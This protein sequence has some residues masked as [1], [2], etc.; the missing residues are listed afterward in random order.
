MT[1]PKRTLFIDDGDIV[2]KRN[3][4]RITHAAEKYEGNP[5]VSADQ[6]WEGDDVSMAGTVR[7]DNGRFRMWY[8]NTA[9]QTNFNLYAESGDGINWAK[10][11]LGMYEDFS[12]STENNIYMSRVGIR[13]GDLAPVRIKQDHN[14]NVL[15]TPHMG[16]GRAYTML[17]Y[18]YGR[19]P[20]GPYDGYCLAFSND[21]L[22]WTDGPEAPVIPGHADVGRFMWDEDA[23]KFRGIVKSFLNVRGIARRSINWTE[24]DDGFDWV[25]PTPALVPDLQDEE[26]T[27]SR[28]GHYTQFYG[29]PIFR[30]ETMLLGLLQVFRCTD[31]D[32][33]SDGTTDVQLASSRDGRNWDRVGARTT[34]LERS[35]IGSWDYGVVHTGNALVRDGDLV[36]TYYSGFNCRHGNHG[37][38]PEGKRVAI[39]TASWRR[40]RF[41]GLR[42]GAAGGEV[43]I[44]QEVEGS[45][46]HLNA[47]AAGGSLVV[48]LSQDGRPLA[49]FEASSFL[50]L[51]DDSLDHVV[52]WRNGPAFST[53]NGKSVDIAI[54]L[55][56]AELF[57]IW[58]Q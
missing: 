34:V 54:K 39:G 43:Q 47:D 18:D 4:D 16:P 14:Q 52:C 55:T 6:P 57:S 42:A 27:D 22:H 17:S 20:Y 10:P 45:E 1:E 30:Y 2:E 15:H 25:M 48:E 33:S 12:G 24:S 23:Q 31:G 28:E 13:S 40:D 35:E 21:G 46:L 38:P 44:T 11:L 58:W 19:A 49:G 9:N 29:M 53:I 3:V 36:R 56:N 37:I 51:T 32:N 50:A 8:Q 5:V 26:W 7:S 41:V